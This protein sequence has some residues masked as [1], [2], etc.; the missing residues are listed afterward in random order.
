MPQLF[1]DLLDMENMK[2]LMDNFCEIVGI[3][4]AIIDLEGKVLIGSNWQSVCTDFHRVNQES[5][6]RCIESDT[7]L[8]NQ[9]NNT[10]EYALYNCRN[11]LIDAAAPIVLEGRHLANL[12]VGQFLLEKPDR[13]HFRRQAEGYGF[14]E[15]KY[16][17]AIDKVPIVPQKKLRPILSYLSHFARTLGAM[18]LKEVRRRKAEDERARFTEIL[19]STIDMVAMGLPDGKLTYMNHAGREMIG[20]S[21]DEEILGKS[22]I[23][24]HSE[25]TSMHLKSI[26]IPTAIEQGAWKGETEL[27]HRNGTL[28]PVSQSIMSHRSQSGEVEYLSIIAHDI[29]ERKKAEEEFRTRGLRVQRQ[30]T[31]IVKLANDNAMFEGVLID[32]IK[33]TNEVAVNAIE[34]E[35]TSIWLLSDDRLQLFCVDMYERYQ[36]KH[37]QGITIQ[38]AEHRAFLDAMELMRVVDTPDA[39][40]DPRTSKFYTDYL[41]SHGVKS[42]IASAVQMHGKLVGIVC[43]EHMGEKCEWSADQITFAGEISEHVVKIL[44]AQDRQHAEMLLTRSEKKYRLLHESMMDGFVRVDMKGNI[45]ETNSAFSKMLGYTEA[46]L[47]ELTYRDVTPANWHDYEKK[48]LEDQVLT[49]GYSEVYEKEYVRK[50]GNVFPVELRTYLIR[51]ESGEPNGMWGIVRD[52]SQRK[53]VENEMNRLRNL[54]NNIVNSMPSVLVGV[55][56]KGIITQWN[57]QAER[58]TGVKIEYARGHSLGEVYPQLAR[59]MKNVTEAILHRETRANLKIRS[60]KNGEV[61]YSDVTVY[62][63]VSNGIE[64]AVIRVDDVTERLRIEEMIIQSEKMLSIGGLAAGMA[65]EINNP[66]AGILQNVQV[67]RNRIKKGIPKNQSIA[68]SCGTSIGVIE[69]YMEKR[70]LIPITDS[71][72]ESGKRAARIVENMLSFSRKSESHM[73]P[74]DLA[75]LLDKTL[76]LAENDYDLKKE[77]DFRHIEII[78]EYDES[79]PPVPCEES[80]IQQV[81][82]NLLKNDAQAMAEISDKGRSPRFIL[83]VMP[84]DN[85]VRVEIEDNGPG[86]EES[87]RKHV[88][89]PFFTTKRVG[90]GTGLGLSVSY[91]IITENHGGTMNV[92]SKPGVGT[93]FIVRLPL[94]RKN[95]EDCADTGNVE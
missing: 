44:T 72:M 26:G 12:F 74:R 71:I 2:Q 94:E 30:Q 23:D 17:Q 5:C 20:W 63:L 8:A 4:S 91:F 95:I 73:A 50:T 65:H 6:Q 34:I 80:K 10:G 46:E 14:D 40:S 19:E 22:M 70:E 82:L 36:D 52:I 59:E 28:M 60:E 38:V 13:E 84:E 31:A 83:R 51:D 93:T 75:E 55:D 58:E 57:T 67:L 77:Y 49:K 42:I 81:F 79:T 47:R 43:F 37:S 56:R 69:E 21:Q 3:A 27:L 53:K 78:R 1:S 66:L 41:A 15:D 24:I 90:F 85:M 35:R 39:Q 76:E 9:V 18:G 61:R 92:V 48:I 54:L 7:W 11:G 86:M 88:F 68:E 64:G 87:V 45:V 32:A 16:I 29:S 25:W 62:P 33:K 89:E